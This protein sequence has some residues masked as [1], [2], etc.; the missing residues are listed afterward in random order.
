MASQASPQ[1][2]EASIP[3][4]FKRDE[5]VPSVCVLRVKRDI[6]DIMKE[7]PPGIYIAP[8]ENDITHVKALLVG[9]PDTPY[10]GGFL[11]FHI[12]FPPEYPIKPPKVLL[13]TRDSGQTRLHPLFLENGVVSLSILNTCYGSEWSSVQ[14]LCSLLLS[15]QSLLTD[16]PYYEQEK[17]H[18]NYQG[19]EMYRES[20]NKYKAYVR[21]E[22]VR[23]AVCDAVESCL[24]ELSPYPA[25]LRETVLK[26]FLELYNRYEE[27]VKKELH[28]NATAMLDPTRLL[29]GTHSLVDNVVY[30]G[31]YQHEALLARLQDL[32]AKVEKRGEPA[33]PDANK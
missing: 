19:K 18:R 25:A 7:P 21:H 17:F 20:A 6:E 2:E 30:H 22:I 4:V 8:D 16:D 3:N 15:I 26:V 13:L 10:E 32:K 24:Q 31:T 23:V 28:L 27:S 9:P 33:L 29:H 12:A 14:S 1:G 11:L 5:D